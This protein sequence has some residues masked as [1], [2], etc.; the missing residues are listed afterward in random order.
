MPGFVMQIQYL[1]F[2]AWNVWLLGDEDLINGTGLL[3]KW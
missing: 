2:E 3:Q 1:K